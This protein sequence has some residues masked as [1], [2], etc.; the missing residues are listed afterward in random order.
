M[1][2]IR[3]RTGYDGNE[4]SIILRRYRK[5]PTGSIKFAVVIDPIYQDVLVDLYRNRALESL[6][7][8]ALMDTRMHVVHGA[9]FCASTDNPEEQ[10]GTLQDYCEYVLSDDEQRIA[11]YLYIWG[12]YFIYHGEFYGEDDLVIDM[13][14]PRKLLPGLKNRINRLAELYDVKVEDC[15]NAS[16]APRR[17]PRMGLCDWLRAKLSTGFHR[18]Q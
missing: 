13:I 17:V 2:R 9:V 8:R 5:T 16:E 1:K 10:P 3:Y 15:G 11:G 6:V 4:T 18:Q 7:H 12:S 14:V